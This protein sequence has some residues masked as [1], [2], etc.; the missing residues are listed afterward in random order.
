MAYP[1]GRRTPLKRRRTYGRGL[2]SIDVLFTG[3]LTTTK[4]AELEEKEEGMWPRVRIRD[5]PGINQ[6]QRRDVASEWNPR[7]SWILEQNR[8]IH[9]EQV[10]GTRSQSPMG[11]IVCSPWLLTSQCTM[12]AMPCSLG[13]TAQQWKYPDIRHNL[14]THQSN[15]CRN[16]KCERSPPIWQHVQIQS[17]ARYTNQPDNRLHHLIGAHKSDNGKPWPTNPGQIPQVPEIGQQDDKF[18]RDCK[19]HDNCQHLNWCPL[20]DPP[21]S[22][23]YLERELEYHWQFNCSS[24]LCRLILINF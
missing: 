16:L 18:F 9:L 17:L 5:H 8:K 4:A 20:P 23:E 12:G 7:R 19:S 6:Y 10:G 2:N 13:Q 1:R 14:R 24:P 22:N 11:C 21:S 3:E 15:R